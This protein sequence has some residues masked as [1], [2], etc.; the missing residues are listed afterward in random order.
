VSQ[1]PYELLGVPKDVATDDLQKAYRRLA[2]KLH[3]DLNPGNHVA[4]ERFK[5]VSAAYDLLSDPEKRARYDR[6]EIDASGAERPRTHHR[7]YRDYAA[8][9][10][11]PYRSHAGYSDFMPDDVLAEL[12]RRGARSREGMPGADVHYRLP[13]GFLEAVNGATKRVS[14]TDGS[15]VELRIPAG[16]Q[17]GHVLRLREKGEPGLGTAPP[18]DALF[19]LEVL[20]HRVFERDGD[21]IRLELPISLREAVLGG[22]IEVPTPTGAV[23]MTIPK[24]ANSGQLMRLRGKGAVR[25]DGSRG[26]LYATLRV[27]IPAGDPELEA[28]VGT[29]AASEAY[30]PRKAWQP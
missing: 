9:E 5:R 15:A 11:H 2:K 18:G 10:D 28:F 20:P 22:R 25:P 6:S 14:L 29:W 3:P 4:E 21:D 27:M 12:L 7:F 16:V 8:S 23:L 17:G 30:N 13:I 1:D 19:E 24:G 26:D